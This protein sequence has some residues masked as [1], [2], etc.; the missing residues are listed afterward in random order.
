MKVFSP[1]RPAKFSKPLRF[2]FPRD[3]MQLQDLIPEPRTKRGFARDPYPDIVFTH[4]EK[5]TEIDWAKLDSHL[6]RKAAERRFR[7]YFA[8]N[9]D[10]RIQHV[11]EDLIRLFAEALEFS[12]FRL[13]SIKRWELLTAFSDRYG[14]RPAPIT[15]AAI[16]QFATGF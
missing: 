4:E 6:L 14:D 8:S 9:D 11:T 2:Q 10:H 7:A 16:E 12:E 1:A 3:N 15:P 13:P 5:P